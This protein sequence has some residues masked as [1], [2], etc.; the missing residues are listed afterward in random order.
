VPKILVV[1][2]DPGVRELLDDFL[3]SRGYEVDTASDGAAALAALHRFTPDL[4]LLD[5]MMPGING[6]QVLRDR[7][8]SA[9]EVP[10]IVVTA[11]T[12][13]EIGRAALRAGA[14][15]YVTKPIDLLYLERTIATALL[16]TGR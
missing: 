4:V 11:V 1:D 14:M 12:E 15:D 9:R 10:V 6:M 5:L 13:E 8:E 2:D 3:R 7:P 16:Q